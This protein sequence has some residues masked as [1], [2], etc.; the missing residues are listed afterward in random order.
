MAVAR[1]NSL[2][3]AAEFI[4]ISPSA[5]GRSISELESQLGKMLLRR[6]RRGTMLTEE[7]MRLWQE[8]R[9]YYDGVNQIASRLKST[10]RSPTTITIG[11]DNVSYPPLKDRL[12][13][14]ITHYPQTKFSVIPVQG[15]A[16]VPQLQT[17]GLDFMIS[18]QPTGPSPVN[19]GLSQLVM[20]METIGMVVADRLAREVTDTKE[21]LK[22]VYLVQKFSTLQHPTFRSLE[23]KLQEHGY[24]YYAMGVHELTEVWYLVANGHGVSL[25]TKD[26]FHDSLQSAATVRWFPQ[27]FMFPMHLQR[28]LYF[29]HNRFDELIEMAMILQGGETE[30]D[31]EA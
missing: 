4:A 1:C 18:T 27:P 14:L 23:K 15:K 9:P 20:K 10:N 26:M 16:W 31:N 22:A 29:Y 21:L 5:L 13:T 2:T 17:G 25:M 24:Q 30:P 3:A 19:C 7:G 11:M 6:T 12:A 8:L 28:Y